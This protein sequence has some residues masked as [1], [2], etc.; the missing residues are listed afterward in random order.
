MA[1]KKTY[2]R[3]SS[4]QYRDFRLLWFGRLLSNIGSQMQLIAVNWHIFELLRNQTYAVNF[5]GKEIELGAEALGL[6]MLGLFRVIPIVIF[7]LLGGVLADTRNRRTLMIWVQVASALFAAILAAL[8]FKGSITIPL[9]YLLTAAGAAAAAFDEPARQSIVPNLVPAE[10][11]TNA[12]S[13]NTLLWQLSTVIGPALAGS[14]VA[15]LDV[16]YVYALNAISFIAV[17]ASLVMMEYRG[18]AAT[19]TAGLGWQALV[20]GIRFTYRSRLIWST[21]LLDFFATFF[22]SARM[23]LPI[24]AV[25]VLGTDAVGYGLLATAQPIGAIIAGGI[26]ALRKEIPRQGVVLLISV[27]LYGL[28]TALFGLSTIFPLSY[29]L[30]A[31]TGAGDTVSTVIRGTL[32][33]RITPDHLRG[34]MTSVN[35][36]FFM[37]GPQLGELEAGLVAAVFSA[38]IAIFT[39]GIATVLLTGMIAWKYP[40]LRRYQGESDVPSV[41][42]G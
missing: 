33:Q 18:K 17:I 3:L 13:L 31:L 7:A 32:R 29:I 8:T 36:V 26:V 23:M 4:L 38:P 11:L 1:N 41:A 2:S 20:D 24:V 22:A 12:I 42:T 9:I 14:M 40:R 5:L 34:R 39:G 30:F 19:T 27:A 21:M 25:D 16:G 6:G 15:K 10:H 28:A 35:M 37:G